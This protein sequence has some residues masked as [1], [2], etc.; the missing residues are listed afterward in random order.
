MQHFRASHVQG[1]RQCGAGREIVFHSMY[2]D[3]QHSCYVLGLGP[4]LR[5]MFSWLAGIEHIENLSAYQKI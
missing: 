3:K 2:S 1:I 4:S 5:H